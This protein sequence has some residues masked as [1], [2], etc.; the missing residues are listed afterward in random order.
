[1]TKTNP[2]SRR[3]SATLLSLMTAV[4]LIPAML[5]QSVPAATTPAKPDDTT[6]LEKFVVTGS[7]IKRIDGEGATPL[8]VITPRK[9]KCAASPAPSR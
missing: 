7:M 2:R 5:A 3:V 9:W 4:S 6:K 1:M 8:Q